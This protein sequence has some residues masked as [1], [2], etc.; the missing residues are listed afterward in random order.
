MV[1][2]MMTE[3]IFSPCTA[4]ETRFRMASA[5]WFDSFAA[6]FMVTCTAAVASTTLPLSST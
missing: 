2:V 4:W 6:P 3:P 1:S 5:C